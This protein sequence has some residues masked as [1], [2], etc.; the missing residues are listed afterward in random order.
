MERRAG[1]MIEKYADENMKRESQI[2]YEKEMQ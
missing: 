2:A 1:D